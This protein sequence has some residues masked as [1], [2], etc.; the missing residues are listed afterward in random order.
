MIDLSVE[1][2]GLHLKN[3]IVVA[4]GDIGCHLGQ[5]KEAEYYGA[6]AFITKGCIPRP[7]APGLTRK[8]RFR[9]NYKKGAFRAMAGS[10]RQTLEL[11]EKLMLDS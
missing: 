11:A 1:L 8:A 4:S 6:A 7:G 3:P 5:I 10:R 9:V 2:A